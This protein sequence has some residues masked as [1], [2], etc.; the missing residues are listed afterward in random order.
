MRNDSFFCHIALT[1]LRVSTS[2]GCAR[3]NPERWQR[4][5]AICDAALDVPDNERDTF[6]A[7]ACAGDASLRQEVQ[8]LLAHDKGTSP[9]DQPVWVADNL[10]VQPATLAIG[11]TIGIYRI[12]GVLGA[13]GIGQ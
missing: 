3:M 9:L 6:L 4:I 1:L 8:A 13:G 10:L 5:S 12:D 11:E 7:E 2:V